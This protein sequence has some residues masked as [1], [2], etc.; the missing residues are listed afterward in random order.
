MEEKKKQDV[1]TKKERKNWRTEGRKV[2]LDLS[3]W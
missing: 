1:G 2:Q 3:G